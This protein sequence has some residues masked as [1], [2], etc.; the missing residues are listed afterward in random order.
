MS[1]RRTIEAVYGNGPFTITG[2]PVYTTVWGT[3]SSGGGSGP[4]LDV[5]GVRQT[6][7]QTISTSE[8]VGKVYYFSKLSNAELTCIGRMSIIYSV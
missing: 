6:P 1:F 5:N 2:S 8:T 3:S 7:I 4:Q